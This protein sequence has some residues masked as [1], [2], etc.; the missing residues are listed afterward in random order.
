MIAV[1]FLVAPVK[2][3]LIMTLNEYPQNAGFIS[4]INVL[5]FIGI[6]L[7]L[8]SVLNIFAGLKFKQFK[9]WALSAIHVLS[10]VMIFIVGGLAIAWYKL[11]MFTINNTQ[12]NFWNYI[13][14]FVGIFA[15]IVY[16]G[17]IL[18]FI[19]SIRTKKFKDAYRNKTII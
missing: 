17:M 18:Y 11:W 13:G 9:Q 19:R 10:Y 5:P 6:F 8:V 2:E 16:I 12:E 4:I 15:C 1:Y 14:M 7:T 3:K